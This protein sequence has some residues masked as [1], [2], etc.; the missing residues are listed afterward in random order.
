MQNKYYCK[1]NCTILQNN[2]ETWEIGNITRITDTEAITN[3]K[4]LQTQ[5]Q[6]QMIK[7]YKHRHNYK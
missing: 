3:D 1:I 7:N 2:L 4:E 6:L 5:T